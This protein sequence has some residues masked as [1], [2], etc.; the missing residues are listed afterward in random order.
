M[1]FN[2]IKVGT[3][4]LQN[5]TT[6]DGNIVVGDNSGINLTTYSNN[7]YIGHSINPSSQSNQF[8]IQQNGSTLLSG[9]FSTGHLSLGS[10]GF[11]ELLDIATPST[12]RSDT[13]GRLYKKSGNDGIFWLP[14][15]GGNELDITKSGGTDSLQEAYNIST[16]P[17]II[18]DATRGSVTI[19]DAITPIGSILLEIVG[20]NS[21]P[22]F[23]VDTGGINVFGNIAVTGTVDSVDL[24]IL[25]TSID[26]HTLDTAN[27]HG[28]TWTQT[29]INATNME[30]A[31]SLVVNS[32]SERTSGSGVSVENVICKDSYIQ[33]SQIATPTPV[34]ANKSRIYYGTDGKLHFIANNGVVE[35]DYD[36]TGGGG[37]SSISAGVPGTPG[38]STGLTFSSDPII[39]TGSISL[40]NTTVTPG[41]YTNTDITVDEN[42]RI[43]SAS[44]GADSSLL[45]II[46]GTPG[47]QTGSSGLTFGT[48]G[49]DTTIAISNTSVTPGSYTNTNIT[50]DETGRITSAIT[51]TETRVDGSGT[52]GEIAR[53]NLTSNIQNSGISI[54]NTG[55]ITSDGFVHIFGSETDASSL[56]YIKSDLDSSIW[57]ESDIDNSNELHNGKF[58]MSTKNSGCNFAMGLDYLEIGDTNSFGN[59]GFLASD[60]IK[61]MTSSNVSSIASP[62][63]PDT[64]DT[65]PTQAI[66]FSSDKKITFGEDQT[67]AGVS[68]Y[69]F[70]GTDNNYTTGCKLGFYT[71]LDTYPIIQLSAI[72]HDNIS[73]GFDAYYDSAGVWRSSDAGSSYA[74]HKTADELQFKYGIAASGAALSTVILMKLT[75]TGL[76]IGAGGIQFS[77]TEPSSGLDLT[78]YE[79]ATH[80]TTFYGNVGTTTTNPNWIIVRI[81]DLIHIH[82]TGDIVDITPGSL[83][84]D[85]YNS[86]SNLLSSFRPANISRKLLRY[87]NVTTQIGYIEVSTI[88]DIALNGFTQNATCTWHAPSIT[89]NK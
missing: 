9:D 82:C 6:G 74:I 44:T 20:T 28:S 23:R 38:V 77:N 33:F 41:S 67:F 80:S 1:S 35:T 56:F 50:V 54:D 79:Y 37:V 40:S 39:T 32:I 88:G 62:P 26:N 29:S 30:I 11:I 63:T 61:F 14:D 51:G 55:N 73:F 70:T 89:Y 53:W 22:Y 34:E 66:H 87:T 85:N 19:R 8:L 76:Q 57:I 68:R 12:D 46:D 2:N 27:P 3:S 16:N 45:T 86:N 7:V 81:G 71:N 18:L 5:I 59:N 10:T 21:T 4:S 60:D 84:G 83:S 58:I 72:S 25:N 75:T 69:R 49:S 42:G 31:T 15:V 52:D 78:Y 43:T 48:S 47:I 24:S 17:E 13:N 36:L 65:A 64:W